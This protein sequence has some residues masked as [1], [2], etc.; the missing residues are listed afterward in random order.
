M[1]T[2]T[3]E[4]LAIFRQHSSL[5]IIPAGQELFRQGD[6]LREVLLIETGL[7]KM[8]R[9]EINGDERPIQFRSSGGILGTAAVFSGKPALM[10]AT[11]LNRC[12]VSRLSAESFRG[13][14]RNNPALTEYLLETLSLMF[15]EQA[16]HRSQMK[17]LPARAR[18]ALLLL[19]FLPD[20][21]QARNGDIRLELPASHHDLA[22]FLLM[23]PEHF[24]RML[25][26]LEDEGIIR[27]RNGWIIVVSLAQLVQEAEDCQTERLT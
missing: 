15:Y 11:A 22:G 18:V 1:K 27:R 12:E 10:T 19:Q 24:S 16:V 4:A 23:S 9:T 7:V 8:S 14:V 20:P 6:E 5:Q 25:R 3:L 26:E 17:S 21:E 13:L 2:Q